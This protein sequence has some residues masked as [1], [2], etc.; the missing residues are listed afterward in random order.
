MQDV[1]RWTPLAFSILAV[2]AAAAAHEP[3]P[4]PAPPRLAL[5]L[6]GGGARGLAHIGVLRA[7]E[8]AGLPIDA[9]AGNSMGSVVGSIYASGRTPQ[10]LEAIV[11]SLDWAALF[12][13]RPDR[14]TIPLA[15]RV[16]TYAA[17][18]GVG[19]GKGLELKGGLLEDHYINRF[20]IEQLAAAGWAAGG[21]FDR[22]PVRF[23]AVAGD[24]DTGEQV[25]MG[26]GDLALAVRAS[27]SI[28]VA[29]EPVLWEGRRLVDGLIVNNLPVDVAKAFGAAV[30][31]AV[32][33]GSP[34]IEP[35]ESRS[36]I[37]VAAKVN[38]LLARRRYLDFAA[39]PD[40]LVR[41][42]LGG[43]KSTD[44]SG[45]DALIQAGYE[46]GL[47]AV[48]AIRERLAAAGVSD[49]APR[50]RP[51][52]L[53]LEGAPL[54][55][56]GI[57]G[58]ERV[59]QELAQRLL[60]LPPGPHWTMERGLAALDRLDASGLFGTTWLS[61]ERQQDAVGVEVRVRDAP[62]RRIEING[63]YNEW[64]RARGAVRLS[65][66]NA[67]GFGEQLELLAAASEA[68]TRLQGS[69][70][71]A[72]V[73]VAGLGFRIS[74]STVD[75]RPRYFD[76]EGD[77]V[78]RG[79]FSRDGGEVALRSTVPRWALLEAGL[80]FGRVRTHERAG[81]DAIEA[82]DQEGLVFARLEADT[83]DDLA[84]PE[85]GRRLA[86]RG[87]WSLTD[88]GADLSYWQAS[89]EARRAF[90][91]GAR[92]TVQ[93]D[94]RGGFSGGDLPLYEQYRAGGAALP[95]YREEELKGAQALTASL[96]LRHVVAGQLRVFVRGGVGN[97][98]ARV[99]DITADD[100]RYGATIGLYH[101]TP[102][103]PV[104]AE[105]GVRKGGGTV[106]MLSIGW[107]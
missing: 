97:V 106:G 6:S 46:A 61:F 18:F 73:F 101:P 19:Y 12:S 8:E 32:D 20:L 10:E 1:A 52:P 43:H 74:A 27:L 85:E 81:I 49:L 4:E 26:H 7:F 54:A 25:V 69:F 80:R 14:R 99:E 88:L 39:E 63:G 105:W 3:L 104:A 94:V 71:G 42:D 82:S 37:G 75:D 87:E 28:P 44:Y 33:I 79:H 51:T 50:S 67:L 55:A 98:F 62:Q 47:A 41:P 56:V 60:G 5:A 84:W 53:R 58:S 70:R 103:G 31:V 100:L 48:P 34:P 36:M 93:I 29:F 86:L 15:A 24:L 22:L 2:A 38:D 65:N 13:G 9:I 83:L 11:R 89:G 77:E 78:N 16:E 90:G 107:N 92:T 64:A 76:A 102:L 23:R 91:L 59:S 45:E 35:W 96:G 17:T 40:V 21:D 30:V 57:V 72:R 68:E 66:R 95:G